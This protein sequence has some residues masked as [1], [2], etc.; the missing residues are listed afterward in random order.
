[1]RNNVRVVRRGFGCALVGVAMVALAACGSSSSTAAP[2]TQA[3]AATGGSTTTGAAGA[4]T[5][6]V[7]T[8]SNAKLGS[9]LVDTNGM[10]LYT[11]TNGGKAVACTGACATAWPPLLLPSGTTSASGT[12]GVTG[13]GTVAVSGGTQVT[14]N[15]LPLYRF[16]GDSA[17]GDTNGEGLSSFGGTWHVTAAGA[18]TGATG[19]EATAP[20]T[21]PNAPTTT[22]SGGYSYP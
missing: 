21:V 3:P 11:L 19:A 17:S 10:T 5:P 8:A 14:A 15:G 18:A 6:A 9:L 16:S 13:L 12:A 4:S 22:A 2:T 1:M 7:M 20:T